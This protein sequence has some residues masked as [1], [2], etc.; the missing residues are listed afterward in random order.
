M[1][2]TTTL[3]RTSTPR[4]ASVRAAFLERSSGNGGST[5]GP[6]SI[7]MIRAC[8]GSIE[9]KSWRSVRCAISAIAPATSTPVGPPPTITNVSQAR[10]C[11]GSTRSATSNA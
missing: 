2:L 4:P 8:A 7:K 5:R 1:L 9:R 6:P 10:R 11:A 3:V